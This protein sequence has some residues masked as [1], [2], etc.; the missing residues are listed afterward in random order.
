MSTLKL[1]IKKKWFDMILLGEK[2]T[3]YRE[4]KP[5]WIRRLFD[6]KETNYTLE[7]FL[8]KLIK[9]DSPMF[10]HAKRYKKVQFFNGCYFSEELPNFTLEFKGV[11]IGEGVEYWGAEKNTEYLNIYLGKELSRSNCGNK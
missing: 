5:Y 4:L 1:T 7:S 3:E 11:G 6:Y 8:K 9:K 10:I 2:K